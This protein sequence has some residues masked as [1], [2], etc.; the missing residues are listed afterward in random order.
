MKNSN[1]VKTPRPSFYGLETKAEVARHLRSIDFEYDPM[2]TAIAAW[3]DVPY[4]E[5]RN[6]PGYVPGVMDNMPQNVLTG[7]A[8]ISGN[9]L[10][11]KGETTEDSVERDKS[12]REARV[13]KLFPIPQAEKG[14]RKPLFAN[15][16]TFRE[17]LWIVVAGYDPRI[18]IFEDGYEINANGYATYDSGQRW[19]KS[20]ITTYGSDVDVEQLFAWQRQGQRPT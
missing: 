16:S 20:A 7:I 3:F 8:L 6:L 4:N 15:P 5:V 18:L 17:S 1:L 11:E 14:G 19:V 9:A 13:P 2:K 10:K 12:F